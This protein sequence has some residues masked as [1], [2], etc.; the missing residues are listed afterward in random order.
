M[1]VDATILI[2]YLIT[3]WEM[4]KYSDDYPESVRVEVVFKTALLF[5]MI[6]M[7]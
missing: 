7:R 1:M 2:R 3:I 4:D 5:I 6:F